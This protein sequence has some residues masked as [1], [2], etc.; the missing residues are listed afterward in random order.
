MI[1]TPSAKIRST[2]AAVMSV[3]PPIFMVLIFPAATYFQKDDAQIPTLS[4]NSGTRYAI[5]LD[6]TWCAVPFDGSS[7]NLFDTANSK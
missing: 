3:R 6:A 2:S 4:Q 5:R 7:F 1:H